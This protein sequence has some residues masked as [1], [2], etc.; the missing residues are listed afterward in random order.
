MARLPRY[1]VPDVP[2]HLIQR[3]NDRQVIFAGDEDFGYFRD[4]LHDAAH[5]EGLAIHAY[6]FMTNHVHLLATPAAAA[7][8][9]RTPQ[10]AG[11]R[12]VQ[13]FNQRDQHIGSLLVHSGVSVPSA[14]PDPACFHRSIPCPAKMTAVILAV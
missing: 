3:G 9:G 13:Y 11:R 12:Y 5:R 4:C 10:S 14:E 1:F 6:V 2:L 7:S 8:A